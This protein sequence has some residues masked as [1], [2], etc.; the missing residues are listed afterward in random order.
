MIEDFVLESFGQRWDD[1]PVVTAPAAGG[2]Q[3]Q[4][5]RCNFNHP[6]KIG[7][8]SIASDKADHTGKSQGASERY[9]PYRILGRVHR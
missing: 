2:F 5:L 6:M 1:D 8:S 9:H 3:E 4:K 7:S